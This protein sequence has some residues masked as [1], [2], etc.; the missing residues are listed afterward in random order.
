MGG[1]HATDLISLTIVANSRFRIWNARRYTCAI[2][3]HYLV[4][5]TNNAPRVE[6]ILQRAD[7]AASASLMIDL[8]WALAETE[9]STLYYL[10]PSTPHTPYIPVDH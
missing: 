8:R 2:I 6:D 5:I 7:R 4:M 9:P 1:S 3:M 10:L